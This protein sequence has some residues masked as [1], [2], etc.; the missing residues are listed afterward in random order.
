[1]SLHLVE[2]V[3]ARFRAL[4]QPPSVRDRLALS[5]T[6]LRNDD[7]VL[8]AELDAFDRGERPTINWNLQSENTRLLRTEWR[9]IFQ[10]FNGTGSPEQQEYKMTVGWEHL[11]EKRS[12]HGVERTEVIS[13]GSSAGVQ[14][15]KGIFTF[16]A[17]VTQQRDMHDTIRHTL[18][19]ASTWR[20]Y[21]SK[22]ENKHYAIPAGQHLCVY[23]AVN[24]FETTV[25]E[26]WNVRLVNVRL[27]GMIMRGG[28]IAGNAER[29]LA[30]PERIVTTVEMTSKTCSLG[31]RMRG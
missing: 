2:E 17:G 4:S 22:E 9:L 28:R 30:E 14:A 15:V 16:N 27:A 29:Y 23:Q 6:L 26:V 25:P 31:R 5:I 19:E 20:F 18:S 13:S 3:Q 11:S 21:E 12:E 1:M 24:V 7:A 8:N 10:H